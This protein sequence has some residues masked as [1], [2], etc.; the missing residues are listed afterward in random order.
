[1]A[2]KKSPMMDTTSVSQ[3][4][5]A[6]LPSTVATPAP[7][8][9]SSSNHLA[10]AAAQILQQAQQQQAQS[11]VPPAQVGAH[12]PA[13]P[14]S[15]PA[16]AAAKAAADTFQTLASIMS[17]SAVVA[18]A[19]KH[20]LPNSTP[21]SS[22]LP[23]IPQIGTAAPPPAPSSAG[24]QQNHHHQQ[25]Q[26][27]NA[28]T[29]QLA[30]LLSGVGTST[31]APPPTAPAPFPTQPMTTASNPLLRHPTGAEVAVAAAAASAAVPGAVA[32]PNMQNWSLD[33]LRKSRVVL[34]IFYHSTPLTR[35]PSCLCL[36]TRTT[37]SV[38]RTNQATHSANSVVAAG[39]RET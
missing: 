25:Q 17:S 38:A 3:K 19:N 12:A 13:T 6:T 36:D 39:R 29:S 9:T 16:S 7:S 5:Q 31:K 10:L 37:Y 1:M 24:H 28:I 34:P 18:A 2:R 20:L 21:V 30:A 33:Q 32:M 23:Q 15:V 35:G 8:N 27:Q 14:A 22:L 26:Q 4:E 11:S